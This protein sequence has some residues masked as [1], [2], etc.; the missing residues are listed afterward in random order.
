MQSIKPIKILFTGGGS[1][2]HIYPIVAVARAL[3]IFTK[4][5]YPLRL[6][7]LGPKDNFCRLVLAREGV[8][9]KTITAGKI[10]RYLNPL[11]IMQNIVDS[12]IKIPFGTVQAFFELMFI[13]PDIIF[14]KGG[15]GS[16][17]VVA[18]ARIL[19]IPVFLQES[20]IVPGM[21]S[22]QIAPYALEI[23]TSFPKTEFFS[24]KKV[25][26]VGN[27]IR[28][29]LLGG[30]KESA[31]KTYNLVGGR[32]I[33]FVM[34]G[35]LG[36]QR[37]N[38][39]ILNILPRLLAQYEVIHQAGAQNINQLKK[40]APFAAP[41]EALIYY[42]PF[43][44]ANEKELADAYA[45]A[46]LIIS[47]AGAGSIFEIAAVKKPS[48]LI[49]LPE[50]AQN[51]QVK[52]AYAYAACGAALVFEENNFTPNLFMEKLNDLLS[53]QEILAVMSKAAGEF[54]RPK[55]AQII[56]EYIVQ[57]LTN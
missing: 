3:K 40:E 38:N 23:F 16:F 26:T 29:E 55:A 28:L 19:G 45:A 41:K 37:I 54:A 8:K 53:H 7:Y 35:S 27:P 46:D 17:P 10:R 34:G 20:D 11:A 50:A 39:K 18:S 6:F 42:H 33:I 1:G 43:G 4:G 48:I 44:L 2:G 24:P 13:G 32:P 9:V 30:T 12:L 57:Y 14:S 21:A 56:A 22:R 25:I 47:R 49:P 52:N 36:A 51:H 31:A 5:K 15:Y